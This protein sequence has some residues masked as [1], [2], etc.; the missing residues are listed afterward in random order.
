MRSLEAVNG[1]I[2]QQGEADRLRRFWNERY[3]D[4][5]LQE[6]GI[7]GL[8]AEYIRLLYRCKLAAWLDALGRAGLSERAG[9]RVLDAGCGQGFFADAAVSELKYANYTGADI[10]EKAIAHLRSTRPQHRWL[11]ADFCDPGFSASGPFDVVQSIEVMHLILDNTNHAE[12]M[13]NFARLLAPGGRIFVTDTLPRQYQVNPYMVFRPLKH[14]K[15]LAERLG[16]RIESVRP[17]YYFLPSRGWNVWPLNRI[18]DQLSPG[19]V[20]TLDRAALALRLPQFWTT[21]DSRM[22]M[23]TLGRP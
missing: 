21:H 5:S 22:K 20:Y 13:A 2:Q 23:I 4:F 18:L 17:M 11:S 9:L 16:L 3:Q 1:P 8:D 19:F 7:K 6:S 15:E 10:S 12:A 14:Y